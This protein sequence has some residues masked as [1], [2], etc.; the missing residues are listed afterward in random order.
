MAD[1]YEKQG[2]SAIRGEVKYSYPD[3][4]DR[5]PQAILG[6][7]VFLLAIQAALCLWTIRMMSDAQ[8]ALNKTEKLI[9]A[10]KQVADQI[11][12]VT[13]TYSKKEKKTDSMKS[14]L[15]SKIPSPSQPQPKVQTQ[16]KVQKTVSSYIFNFDAE[17]NQPR[18]GENLILIKKNPQESILVRF[19]EAARL[20]LAGKGLRIEYQFQ[21]GNK[22]SEG[23]GVE[24]DVPKME[25]T[26]TSELSFWIKGDSKAGFNP[27]LKLEVSDGTKVADLPIG[28]ISGFWKHIKIPM[29]K[30]PSSI[31]YQN[32]KSIKLLIQN[33]ANASKGAYSLDQFEI[34]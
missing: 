30:M 3:K 17:T 25:L 6:A 21:E 16:P 23:L 24:L 19:E 13:A 22:N 7:I 15:E 14:L 34:K 4:N 18:V 11:D 31:D 8:T 10:L 1:L 12:Q 29:A 32:I 2:N 20:G 9:P 26:P 27:N 28:G 33:G 5:R